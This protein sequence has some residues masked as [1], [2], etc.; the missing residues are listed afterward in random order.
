MLATT[1]HSYL[2]IPSYQKIYI[3]PTYKSFKFAFQNRCGIL[4][5]YADFFF[6]KGQNETSFQV[7]SLCI[8]LLIVVTNYWSAI[9]NLCIRLNIM[10]LLERKKF[11]GNLL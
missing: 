9:E 3:I 5:N 4:H 6:L 8:I 2:F 1:L 11:I 10:S 7:Q